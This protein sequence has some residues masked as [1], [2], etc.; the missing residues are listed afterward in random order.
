ME[1]YLTYARYQELGG[2]LEEAPFNLLEYKSQ[3]LIDK[4]SFNRLVDGVPTEIK[5]QIELTT[6]NLM[7][8]VEKNDSS[9]TGNLASETIDGYSVS[10]GG[11]KEIEDKIKYYV[12][13]LLAGLEKDGVPLTYCGDVN[14][15]K[16]I[17]YPIS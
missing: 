13:D 6:M 8:F 7:T 4:Y 3:K 14:D 10:Y 2:T 16:R 17:Y 12:G 15:Y 5:E 9:I 1:K 11:S